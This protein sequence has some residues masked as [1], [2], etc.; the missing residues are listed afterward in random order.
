MEKK[1]LYR[2]KLNAFLNYYGFAY[3]SVKV[4]HLEGY[5]YRCARLAKDYLASICI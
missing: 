2:K 5:I 1:Y 4:G 3:N